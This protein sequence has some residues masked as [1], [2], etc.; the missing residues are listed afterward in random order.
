VLGAVRRKIF[1]GDSNERALVQFNPIVDEVNSFAPTIEALSDDALSE[2]TAELRARLEAGE[3]VD[4]ILTEGLAVAREAVS[5]ATGE[6]AYDVQILGAIVLH[7]G[8]IAEMRT[9]EG[10]TL[11]ATLALYVNALEG[12]GAHL[13]TVNDYLA[14]RDA[15]WYGPALMRL[16]MSIGILQNQSAYVVRDEQV[17]DQSSFEFL[18]AAQR[19]EVYASDI[20]YGTNNEFGFDYLRDNMATSQDGRVQ[21]QRHFAIVDEADSVLIDEART[22]LIISGSGQDDV[23]LYPRFARIVPQLQREVD[24]TVDER[25][26][27]VGLTESGVEK[28]ERALGIDNIYSLQN[29]GLTRYM[30]AALKAQIIYQRDKDYVVKDNQIVIVDAFT[31][32]LMEGRRWSDGLH[33]AV[34]AKEGVKVQ[35]ES[36]TYATITIQNFFR[37]YNT[38]SGMTGTAVTEAEELAEIYELEVVIVPTHRT[39]AREDMPDL[40]FRSVPAKWNAVVEDITEKYDEG[41]PVLVGTVAIETSEMLSELLTRRGI[42]HEVL[43]AKQHQREASIVASAGARSAVTIATNMAGRGTDIKLGEGVADLGGLHVIGTE[44]H[45]SRRID[46]Q[47]RGRSGR[48]GDPG[49]T[50]FFVSFEDDLMKRFAPEWLPGMMAKLG[51]EEDT[52]L[53]SKMVTKAIE[54]AQQRVEGYNFD[55]RKHVVEYDDVMNTHRD[56]IYTER[57]K[58]L[59]GDDLRETVVTMVEDE[60]EAMASSLLTDSPPEPDTFFA[61]LEASVPLQ[62]ELTLADVEAGPPDA[63]IEQA[64]DIV[65]KRYDELETS[66]GPELQRLV[67]RLVLLR[68][69]DSLWVNHLTAMDDMRQGIGLRA[70]GQTDP[71]VAYK[72]EAHDMWEQLGENIRQAV[73]RNIF[74][75]RI[76]AAQAKHALGE[77]TPQQQMQTSGPTEPGNEPTNGTAPTATNGAAG[78]PAEVDPNASRADRRRAERQQKKAKKRQQTR[79]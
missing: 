37:L 60:I 50:R 59:D 9:G 36:V 12:K 25:T 6:R 57:D 70:Y 23:R 16:G 76:A 18:E 40:V 49:S 13:V 20:V 11:V 79:R 72:R 4:D 17:S 24:Y 28:L 41:R 77:H 35:Q 29:Y 56:V 75:T 69:I 53:E 14:R 46:N 19:R 63:I 8:S 21:K 65:E 67:E 71:L 32:R 7:R 47:L 64:L 61:Q 22:P 58:V 45:E 15:Q 55:I 62:D 30:E 39:I 43:N 1:G 34:E 54:Q 26:R 2:K 27:N 42:T 44:R 66:V 78:A 48:Q 31:G 73:A 10:K 68:T 33:Q 38:L 5:R 3:T 51:M 74:H 52:P